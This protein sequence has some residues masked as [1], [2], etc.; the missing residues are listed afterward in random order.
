MLQL[1]KELRNGV[2]DGWREGVIDFPPTYKYGFNTDVYVGE[3]PKEGE[4][5]RSPAW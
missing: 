3:I 5:R 4:K 2:F 1:S